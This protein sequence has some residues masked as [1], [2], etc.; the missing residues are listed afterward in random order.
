VCSLLRDPESSVAFARFGLCRHT[1]F[2]RLLAAVVCVAGC[3]G[4]ATF[5]PDLA[6]ELQS[7]VDRDRASY[8]VPALSVAVVL[9]NGTVWAG[10]SGEAEKKGRKATTGTVFAIGSI[11]K[12]FVSALA[13]KLVEDGELSLDDRIGKWVPELPRKKGGSASLRQLLRHRS[14]IYNYTENPTFWTAVG[15]G[16]KRPADVLR[17]VKAPYFPPGKGFWYSNTNYILLGMAIERAADRPLAE[18][19]QSR[20]LEPLGLGRISLQ[21][22]RSRSTDFAHGYTA[23]N[24]D[25]PHEDVSD[26][27]SLVPNV[28][29]A[30]WAWAAGGMAANARSVAVWADALFNGRVLDEASLD[31]MID[32]RRTGE[33][34]D[35]GFGVMRVESLSRSK[36]MLGHG[37][38]ID[39]FQSVMWYVPSE[40]V[41]IVVLV[42][43]DTSALA[44]IHDN[45]LDTV[46]SH[47]HE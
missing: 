25:L 42:N 17:Y 26:G 45:L 22:D 37:G 16:L 46:L 9:P 20:L 32:I 2:V 23:I 41:T 6:R 15:R 21:S 43:D 31:A 1:R 36:S 8:R 14:G 4:D 38:M 28:R 33:R 27:T 18:Q 11:T 24:H 7:Q 10:A 40:D 5:N 13:L 44:N 3:G 30:R 34:I 35:Y 29:S 39:G 19:I 12:T 47:L